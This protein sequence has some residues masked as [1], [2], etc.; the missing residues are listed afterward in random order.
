MIERP[1]MTAWERMVTD[2]HTLGLSPSLHPLGLMRARLP[3]GIVSAKELESLPDGARVR[4][5]GLVVCR[6]R[7]GTAQGFTFLLVEDETGMANAI[8][9]PPLYDLKRPIVRG[10]TMVI[11]Q[12]KLQ[13]RDGNINILVD[14]IEALHEASLPPLETRDRPGTDPREEAARER[15]PEI[16]A[17]RSFR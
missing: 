11:V 14:D 4:V 10:E 3:A 6:Q 8:I 5:A 15:A 2:Y 12:G 9:R 1:E 16:P 13:C 7:P 17:A